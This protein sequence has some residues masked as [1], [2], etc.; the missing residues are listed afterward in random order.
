MAAPRDEILPPR[1]PPPVARPA[2]AAIPAPAPAPAPAGNPYGAGYQGIGGTK[3]MSPGAPKTDLTGQTMTGYD[4]D[5]GRVGSA[6][7]APGAA[8]PPIDVADARRYEDTTLGAT[9]GALRDASAARGALGV[10]SM[11]GAQIGPAGDQWRARQ[12]QMIAA[13]E[14]QAAGGRTEGQDQLATDL[15]QAMAM[16]RA[17]AATEGTA[18]ARRRAAFGQAEI[19]QAGA[20]QMAELRARDQIAARQQLQ[21]V[22]GDVRGMDIGRATQ[23]AGFDQATA[24]QN[25]GAALDQRAQLD[26]MERYYRSTGLT[27]EQAQQAAWQEYDRQRVNSELRQYGLDRGKQVATMQGGLT[28][29]GVAASTLGT[30]GASIGT[31]PRTVT[32]G[33]R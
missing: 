25:M 14:A 31:Q 1:K 23:Q 16:Q 33:G 3:I 24:S 17:L 11:T 32:G 7:L 18:Q 27:L 13:L 21:G 2:P 5:P 22:L 19:G 10:D 30:L 28:A 15:G 29:A 8:P 12:M 26:D 4:N 9:T 6:G 20:S